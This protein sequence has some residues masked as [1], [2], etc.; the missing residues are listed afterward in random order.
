MENGTIVTSTTYFKIISKG[1]H[2]INFLK[3]LKTKIQIK[4]C[5][6]ISEFAFVLLCSSTNAKYGPNCTQKDV[7]NYCR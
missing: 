6:P 4:L 2:N 7:A 3:Q 5:Y 1:I